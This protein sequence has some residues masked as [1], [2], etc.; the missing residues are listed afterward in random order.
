MREM[1][2]EEFAGWRTAYDT[3]P[4][5]DERADLSRA[6]GHS[7]VDSHRLKAKPKPY[8]DYMPFFREPEEKHPQPGDPNLGRQMWNAMA[9]AWNNARKRNK[10]PKKPVKRK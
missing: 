6:V 1:P 3:D 2:A 8:K 7:I 4:W 10:A 9:N 5:G